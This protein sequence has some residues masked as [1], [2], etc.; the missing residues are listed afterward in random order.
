MKIR[1][2]KKNEIVCSIIGLGIIGVILIYASLYT[3]NDTG[4]SITNITMIV[5][6]GIVIL[7]LPVYLLVNYLKKTNNYYAIKILDPDA[8]LRYSIKTGHSLGL[9]HNFDDLSKE[10]QDSITERLDL[11]IRNVL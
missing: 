4:I 11:E 3:T 7:Y 6:G 1:K 5:L 2:I 9:P 8:S 10:E